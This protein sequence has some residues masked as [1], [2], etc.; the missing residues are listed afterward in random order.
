MYVVVCKGAGGVEKNGD[1][2]ENAIWELGGLGCVIVDL[3]VG[4][5]F[6]WDGFPHIWLGLGLDG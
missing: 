3:L 6:R 4:M 1:D 2:N 5:E